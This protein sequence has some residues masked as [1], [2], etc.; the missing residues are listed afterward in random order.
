MQQATQ[1]ACR[2]RHALQA[3]ACQACGGQVGRALRSERTIPGMLAAG[4]SRRSP[5]APPAPPPAPR[6][7]GVWKGSQ[8][9]FAHSRAFPLP[10]LHLQK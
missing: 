3:A 2:T 5:P 10:P 9:A 6:G 1:P 7:R 8:A 4:K